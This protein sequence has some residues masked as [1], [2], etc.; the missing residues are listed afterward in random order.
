M[1]ELGLVIKQLQKKYSINGKELAKRI[2]IAAPNLSQIINGHA[3]PRQGTFSKLCKELGKDTVDEK[4]LVDSFLRL[5]DATPEAQ[6]LNSSDYQQTEIE[7]AERY[8]EMKVQSIAFKRAVAHELDK[9]GIAYQADYCVGN[10]ITDFLL[11]HNGKR[12]ALECKFNAQR[13]MSKAYT[14]LVILKDKLKCDEAFI[15]VPN[16]NNLKEVTADVGIKATIGISQLIPKLH[17]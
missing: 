5:K 17:L 10:Y 13:D 1:N 3:K 2:N 9:A 16:S 7:R 12:I 4:R 14:I 15:V 11:E 8:L 6:I